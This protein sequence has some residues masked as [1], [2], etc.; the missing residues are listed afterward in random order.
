MI[1]SPLG[2][3][4]EMIVPGDI[5]GSS[6][7]VSSSWSVEGDSDSDSESESEGNDEEVNWSEVKGIFY[8]LQN[9]WSFVNTSPIELYTLHALQPNKFMKTFLPYFFQMPI[10]Q[11]PDELRIKFFFLLESWFQDLSYEQFENLNM[12]LEQ[13]HKWWQSAVR[14][15]RDRVFF[16]LDLKLR[17]L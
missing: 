5:E 13:F 14:G 3:E 1:N 6:N 8:M 10:S 9:I 17:H 7:K 2:P 15:S 11:P 16:T 4:D 12:S